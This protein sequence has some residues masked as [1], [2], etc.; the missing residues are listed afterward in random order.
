VP[1]NASIRHAVKVNDF[2]IRLVMVSFLLKLPV[3]IQ[4]CKQSAFTASVKAKK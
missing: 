4:L 1:A 2:V 3:Q